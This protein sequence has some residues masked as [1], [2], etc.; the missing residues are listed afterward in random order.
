MIQTTGWLVG[1]TGGG[2]GVAKYDLSSG[3]VSRLTDSRQFQ[4][5][6]FHATGAGVYWLE[7]PGSETEILFTADGVNVESLDFGNRFYVQPLDLIND[8]LVFIGT[9]GD[10]VA[11]RGESSNTII[12]LSPND[13]G[14]TNDSVT[15]SNTVQLNGLQFIGVYLNSGFITSMALPGE[16][17]TCE[18][19]SVDGSQVNLPFR[20]EGDRLV[21]NGVLD[22]ETSAIPRLDVRII[23]SLGLTVVRTF[24]VFVSDVNENSSAVIQLSSSSLAENNSGSVFIGNLSV[25]SAAG[26]FAYS[27]DPTWHESSFF[28]LDGDALYFIGY[29]DFETRDNYSIRV[30]ASNGTAPDIAQYQLRSA[31]SEI[32]IPSQYRHRNQWRPIILRGVEYLFDT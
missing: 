18:V 24:Q 9:N 12:N 4:A 30:V 21:V 26:Q 14:P 29:A 31:A 28:S 25:P 22:F 6:S 7:K 10:G 2:F 23:S 13:P 20:V 19:L 32:R 17:I 27:L 15:G 3:V 16:L 1:L 11:L 5:Y 8:H